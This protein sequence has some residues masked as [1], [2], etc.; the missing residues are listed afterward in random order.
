MKHRAPGPVR[1]PRA[2][3]YHTIRSAYLE[4][5]HKLPPATII[6]RVKRYDFHDSLAEGLSLIQAGPVRAAWLLARSRIS[7]LEV[8]EPLM[9]S[10]L[11]GSALAIAG[12]RLRALV[13]RRRVRVVSYA[14]ENA[15]PFSRP[16]TGG[17]KARVR[18]LLMRMLAPVV[19]RQLDRIVFATDAARET[20]AAAL[21]APSRGTKVTLMPALPAACTCAPVEH[22][23]PSGV[24]FLGALVERKGLLLVL[25][26]WPLVRD[27]IPDATLTIVGKGA[28][29]P[30]V[31]A[32]A[33]RD[34]SV[35]VIIDPAREEVHHQLRRNRVLVLP[36]LPTPIWREQVGLPIVEG[37]AHG[38]T[39]VTTTETGLAAWLLA[40][41]HQV[42]APDSAP[43]Q[44][45][46]A[47]I[48]AV[49]SGRT[50]ESVLQDLPPVDGRLGADAWLSSET[51]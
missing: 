46:E 28:L 38:S 26:A 29:E 10:S 24:L 1:T 19:W 39:V 20:Y 35:S 47:L 23:D 15:N 44:L 50:P 31:R 36:S 2:R 11:T 7:Q 51:T 40:H 27:A 45:A 25:D 21:P 12:V 16:V 9:L 42:I 41:G 6:Y 37:L 34:P 30:Q 22:V 8:N 4:R 49:R 3:L 43:R 17:A 48:V 32:A 14:M 13:D 5:A 18:R 33:V